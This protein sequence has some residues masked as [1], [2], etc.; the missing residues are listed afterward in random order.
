M[1]ELG[2]GLHDVIER[3]IAATFLLAQNQAGQIEAHMK[4]H[5]PWQDRTGNAR[6]GLTAVA[7]MTRQG[8]TTR[9]TIDMGHSV[10]YGVFL[11]KANAG[12]YA[13]VDP[14][15]DAFGPEIQRQVKR[16]WGEP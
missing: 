11:E 5:A 14:T 12:R 9:I 10:D 2:A 16:I 3:R 13:I 7:T 15:A 1:A 6:N 8:S 4:Q